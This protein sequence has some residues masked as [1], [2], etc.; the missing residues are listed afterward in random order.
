MGRK[1]FRGKFWWLLLATALLTLASAAWGADATKTYVNG[2]E[3]DVISDILAET[4]GG[5]TEIPKYSVLA[6]PALKNN[7]QNGAL[8]W[9]LNA[10]KQDGSLLATKSNLSR[11]FGNDA[12]M[13]TSLNYGGIHPIT[14]RYLT[15]GG[16]GRYL[17]LHS[18]LY[19]NKF[20][21]QL[22]LVS[23]KQGGSD[24][25]PAF[26][27]IGST[28][29]KLI[30]A[31]TQGN[32]YLLDAKSGLRVNRN[33]DR[34]EYFVTACSRNCRFYVTSSINTNASAEL[35]FFRLA[36]DEK[37]NATFTEAPLT[38]SLPRQTAF[39]PAQ[40]AVGDFTGEGIPNQVAMV[41]VDYKAIYLTIFTIRVNS[42]GA[43]EAVKT[44]DD[45]IHYYALPSHA[46]DG[47]YGY[48]AVDLTAGDFD[49]DGK[50]EIAVAFKTDTT[51]VPA[52]GEQPTYGIRGGLALSVFKW[53]NG[54]FKREGI[55]E[56][57]E[58]NF[59]ESPLT[60]PDRT[61]SISWVKPVA[62]DFD[63][64]GKHEIFLLR[65]LWTYRKWGGFVTKTKRDAVASISIAAYSCAKGSI[66]PS[67][68]V[69]SSSFAGYLPGNTLGETNMTYSGPFFPSRVSVVVG[70]FRGKMGTMRTKDDI[71][72]GLHDSY[73][74]DR[75]Y[76]VRLL[77]PNDKMSNFEQKKFEIGQDSTLNGIGLVADDFLHEGA[78]LEQPSHLL[79]SDRWTCSAII[80]APPYHVDTIPVPWNTAAGDKPWPVNF[81]YEPAA[82]TTYS[83]SGSTT[84]VK[85][86]KFEATTSLE[87]IS[88]LNLEM[89]AKDLDTIK[90]VVKVVGTFAF[91]S[92]GKKA[93]EFLG[94]DLVK[95]L[96]DKM[97]ATETKLTNDTKTVGWSNTIE[98]SKVDSQLFYTTRT[99]V[100]RYPV[101]A[102]VPAWLV[103]DCQ[104]GSKDAAKGDFYIT[105]V[106]PDQPIS[107]SSKSLRSAKQGKYANNSLYQPTHEE[108]NLFSYPTTL[109]AIPGYALRQFRL[110]PNVMPIAYSP[111]KE[112]H[113][114]TV[115]TSQGKTES[116]SKEVTSYGTISKA[117]GTV[118]RLTGGGKTDLRPNTKQ[119]GFT[120]K[121]SNSEAVEVNFPEPNKTFPWQNVTFDSQFDMYVDEGGIMTVGFA[122]TNLP[123]SAQL[124]GKDSIYWKKQ[125]PALVLP[126]RYTFLGEVKQDIGKTKQVIARTERDANKM[127]GVRIKNMDTS[128]YT[129]GIVYPGLNF[130]IQVPIYNASFLPE[131]GKKLDVPMSLYYREAGSDKEGELIGTAT[132]K[133]GGWKA[134]TED[135]KALAEFEWK[136]VPKLKQGAWEFYVVID[137]ENKIPEVHEAWSKETPEGN[138]TGYF[139]FGISYGG[140]AISTKMAQKD[141]GVKYK[142]RSGK[143]ARARA[144]SLAEGEEDQV[145]TDWSNWTE[146]TDFS[147]MVSGD[148][149]FVVDI[150]YKD[151]DIL[152]EAWVE[153]LI[154]QKD[155][156]G[157][158]Y[159][160]SLAAE[161]LP[162][163][164]QGDK[165]SFSFILNEEEIAGGTN[166]RMVISDG[167]ETVVFPLGEIP[168]DICDS[169]IS[170][171]YHLSHDFP[172]YW[173]LLPPD[174]TA[175]SMAKEAAV[176][177]SSASES[178]SA[179]ESDGVFDWSWDRDFTEKQD[180]MT[181][182]I[183]TIPGVTPR[184][185][186]IFTVMISDDGENWTEK[187]KL[188]FDTENE[189]SGGGG[190]GCDAGI[191]GGLAILALF[192]LSL[193]RRGK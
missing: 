193:L 20:E 80:Q 43:L 51:S 148:T 110:I 162:V 14:A 130:Q 150:D 92:A 27:K 44:K 145:W 1:G 117:M 159:T 3:L 54:A 2:K 136:N 12:D 33:N 124:W 123:E 174:L 119:E 163:L 4:N 50:T 87:G 53:Q 135:N 18:G 57:T 158:E 179:S 134:G 144:V 37:G 89:S 101:K 156:N 161:M 49:G 32:A 120:K 75:R 67:R 16:K 126:D 173:L 88:S 39:T 15:G 100:W 151:V 166:F 74:D 152:N 106:A 90:D 60:N 185:K 8:G 45:A 84:D 141:F 168:K 128:A 22:Y 61:W 171:T 95:E 182:T 36:E 99:H 157:A 59:S 26:T 112:A 19:G 154:D 181:L 46:W 160:L 40:I 113:K 68:K 169:V 11:S 153:V 137:P 34:E 167:D 38:V 127:R 58:W 139:P 146:S 129:N 190:G 62:A 29:T 183:S 118:K 132:P 189:G 41:T 122:V 191:T 77:Y 83:R 108:G 172:V 86:T 35:S 65:S 133:I 155:S 10:Y 147:A 79:V 6:L 81:N 72:I 98:A 187:E 188:T 116:K 85:D 71:I 66:R 180:K 31:I 55:T 7:G 24:L 125:D 17:F 25:T 63:G 5:K 149:E 192:G 76:N 64:D 138:N 111:N 142:T 96:T 78:E 170:R 91:G 140:E 70:P 52:K 30:P 175:S 47:F 42:A 165:A 102:P 109:S 177:V 73:Y 143:D 186:H 107:G 69:S 97:K 94:G 48:P 121:F 9:S 93:G 21:A 23:T 103:G 28:V 13:G 105:V 115:E 131:G 82:R 104:T 184:G 176:R 178:A 114:A 164:S 56:D